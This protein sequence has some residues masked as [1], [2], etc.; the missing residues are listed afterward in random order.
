ME[1]KHPKCPSRVIAVVEGVMVDL[2]NR[3]IWGDEERVTLKPNEGL[4]ASTFLE[5]RCRQAQRDRLHPPRGQ[6]A[7]LFRFR[8]MS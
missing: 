4:L 7:D 5:N 8:P 3:E 2:D 1:L 6:H